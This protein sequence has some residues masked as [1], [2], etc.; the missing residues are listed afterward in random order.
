MCAEW[1][2]DGGL[3]ICGVRSAVPV[4]VVQVFG[5]GVWLRAQVAG[6]WC[7]VGWYLGGGIATVYVV[8][9]T[10]VDA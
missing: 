6:R 5:G 8:M 2:E 1:F 9:P 3:G 10:R 4:A 7:G